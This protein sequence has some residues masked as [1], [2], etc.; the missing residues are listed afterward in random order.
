MRHKENRMKLI[1]RLL[2]AAAVALLSLT[3][4]APA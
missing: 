1:Q 2:G 3:W 4:V